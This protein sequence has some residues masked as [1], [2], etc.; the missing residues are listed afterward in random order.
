MGIGPYDEGVIA[1]TS[2]MSEDDNPY[3]EGTDAHREWHTGYV[4]GARDSDESDA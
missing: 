1:A 2:G 4:D 3:A